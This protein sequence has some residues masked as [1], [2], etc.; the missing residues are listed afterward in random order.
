MKTR[1]SIP[2]FMVIGLLAPLTLSAQSWQLIGLNGCNL[3]TVAVHPTN[4]AILLASD[5]ASLYRSTNGGTDW[6]TVAFIS[7]RDLRFH[8]V[9]PETAFAIFGDG[10]YSDG[11]WRSV[12]GG[13]TFTVLEYLYRA[14]S[15]AIPYGAQGHLF[16]GQDSAEGVWMSTDN[17][18][19][20]NTYN[21][22]LANRFV[23]SVHCA[24]LSD[25]T[26][27]PLAGTAM[28]IYFC[29]NQGF[30]VKSD[31][32]AD[33]PCVDFAGGLQPTQSVCAAV[34]GGSWSDGVYLSGN[35]GTNWTVSWYWPFMT[36]VLMNPLNDQVLFA[37]DSGYGVIMTTN[38]GVS[39]SEIN[40]NLSDKRVKDLAMS[41][42]DTA[43]LYAATCSG[44][45]R[46][47][48]ATGFHDRAHKAP[49]RTLEISFPSLVTAGA[50]VTIK[51]ILPETCLHERIDLILFDSA[52]RQRAALQA[53]ITD[54]RMEKVLTLPRTPGV[55]FVTVII[56]GLTKTGTLVALPD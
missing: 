50:S 29:N 24:K 6:D 19:T 43:S 34:D 33:L 28:G 46:Y 23:K 2:L 54:R 4:P 45:Y 14:S 21:D 16:A 12:D 41:S 30:W 20:W 8:E 35:H 52:G 31:A 25:S 38:G 5:D 26:Y 18:Q 39:W 51:C 44:L 13:A 17:G 1:I 11:I 7:A 53:F 40:T 10:T 22:S 48:P 49:S 36:A 47:G 56:K 9:S 32:P 55:Y 27:V 15:I 37:A 42:A 3:R